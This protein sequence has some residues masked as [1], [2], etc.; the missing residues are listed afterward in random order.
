MMMAAPLSPSSGLSP[1][2]T[3]GSRS[4]SPISAIGCDLG[5]MTLSPPK[6]AVQ[7]LMVD[8]DVLSTPTLV[9]VPLPVYK[10]HTCGSG[11]HTDY[12]AD[13]ATDFMTG[14]DG[15]HQSQY[16]PQHVQPGPG[17]RPSNSGI[18]R[19]MVSTTVSGARLPAALPS[20]TAQATETLSAFASHPRSSHSSTATSDRLSARERELCGVPEHLRT[21]VW[22]EIATSTSA[23]AASD[24]ASESIEYETVHEIAPT[25]KVTF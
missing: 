11:S 13:A 20:D 17:A 1:S 8:V 2:A 22:G 4:I 5:A 19:R 18:Q 9:T 6:L 16:S 10:Y 12:G 15:K 24:A 21:S 3:A 25:D 7:P 23:A 14:E